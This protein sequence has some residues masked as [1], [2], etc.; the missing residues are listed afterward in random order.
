MIRLDDETMN[1]QSTNK[2]TNQKETQNRWAQ[3][4]NNPS[5]QLDRTKRETGTKPQVWYRAANQ[6]TDPTLS[7]QMSTE[8][9]KTSIFTGQQ[10]HLENQ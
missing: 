3:S 5:G 6:G 7:Q 2:Q 10:R 9:Q 4:G 1:H 8:V